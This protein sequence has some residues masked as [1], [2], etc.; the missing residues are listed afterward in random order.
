MKKSTTRLATAL[1]LVIAGCLPGLANATYYGQTVQASFGGFDG[2]NGFD[3]G[4]ATVGDGVEFTHAASDG[5]G[6]IWTFSLDITQDS[7]IVSWTE[8]TRPDNQGNIWGNP[9]AFLFKLGFSSPLAPLA[10]SHS[11]F[12]SQGQ[13][14]S[15][16]SSISYSPPGTV[17][18]GFN[19]LVSGESYIFSSAV[20]EPGSYAMLLAG[21][22]LVGYAAR[23]RRPT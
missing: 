7:T 8:G 20:P 15:G 16:L 22:G 5:F 18:V 12:T 13:D 6:Q 9:D 19:H 17:K 3:F 2:A 21:L 1:A 23:R 14:P 4:S 11:Q 10:L